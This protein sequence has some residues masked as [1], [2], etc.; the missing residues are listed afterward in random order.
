MTYLCPTRRSPL[1][2]IHQ[3]VKCSRKSVVTQDRLRAL[4]D[5]YEYLASSVAHILRNKLALLSYGRVKCELQLLPPMPNLESLKGCRAN[6]PDLRTQPISGILRR[7]K[8]DAYLPRYIEI[9][10]APTVRTATPRTD[11]IDSSG[12]YIAHKIAHVTADGDVSKSPVKKD[13]K[14]LLELFLLAF[15]CIIHGRMF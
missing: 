7:L 12:T 3:I 14:D 2:P 11:N 10:Q 13:K 15:S 9:N 8:S 4:Q 6:Y 5:R 1:P